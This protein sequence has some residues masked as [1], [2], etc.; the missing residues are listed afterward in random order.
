MAL[1]EKIFVVIKFQ[2]MLNIIQSFY[3]AH[4]KII[5]YIR[6][7]IMIES[8]NILQYATRILRFIISF[9]ALAHV[10]LWRELRSESE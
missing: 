8:N 3:F 9:Y 10:K 4:C 1:S 2:R 6:N 7:N 5:H